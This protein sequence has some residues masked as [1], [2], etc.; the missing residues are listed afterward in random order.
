MGKQRMGEPLEDYQQRNW[1]TELEAAE[2]QSWLELL[3]FQTVVVAPSK[4]DSSQGR[5]LGGS[6][7]QFSFEARPGTRLQLEWSDP[8]PP[9]WESIAPVT[10]WM[11]LRA[12]QARPAN[13]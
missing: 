3:Q 1:Q 6:L 11:Q 4:P 7:Y 8:L 10:Q 2:V 5:T 13:E 12:H 9:E